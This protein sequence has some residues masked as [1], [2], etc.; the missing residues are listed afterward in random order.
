MF[1]LVS[2]VISLQYNLFT[3]CF[4]N[5]WIPIAFGKVNRN[6]SAGAKLAVAACENPKAVYTDVTL[7]VLKD[8]LKEVSFLYMMIQVTLLFY[9]L[10]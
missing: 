5:V 2:S 3:N 8:L 10:C 9:E 6:K 7:A 1:S 4:G